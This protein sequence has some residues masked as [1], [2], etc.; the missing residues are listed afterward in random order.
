LSSALLANTLQQIISSPIYTSLPDPNT[1]TKPLTT[2]KEQIMNYPTVRLHIAAQRLAGTIGASCLTGAGLG[3]A[4]WLDLWPML[5]SSLDSASWVGIGVLSTLIGMRWSISRWEKAKKAWWTDWTRVSEGLR[6]DLRV[7]LERTFDEKVAAVAA[8]SV[9]GMSDLAQKQLEK[10]AE[11]TDEVVD[12]EEDLKM[13]DPKVHQSM[14]S[15]SS[16]P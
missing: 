14:Y 6:R 4:G 3:T 2:R 7:C 10:V 9:E 16:S 8:K 15:E 11:L 1:L 12:L 13:V 5:T